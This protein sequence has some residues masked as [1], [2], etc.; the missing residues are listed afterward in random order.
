MKA[1]DRIETVLR[2]LGIERAHFAGALSQEI[3]PLIEMGRVAS[4]SLVNPNRV[5]IEETGKLGSRLGILTGSSGLPAEQVARARHGLPE[6]AVTV[7]DGCATA[8][9]TDMTREYPEQVLEMLL[10]RAEVEGC[11]PAAPAPATVTAGA[12][13]GEVAGIRYEIDRS[14]SGKPPLVLLPLLLA[15]SQWEPVLDQLASSFTVIRLGGAH[16]GMVAMLESRGRE[17]GYQRILRSVFD[18]IAARPGEVVLEVGCGTG[19]LSRWIATRTRRANPIIAMDLNPYFLKEA[20]AL[21]EDAGLSETL[22]FR[23]G[24]AEVLPFADDSVDITF[25]ST[26][27]EECD[28]DRMLAEMVRVA[29]PGG[30][31]AVVV[32]AADAHAIC[33]VETEPGIKEIVES[34]YRSVSPSGCADASLYRRFAESGLRE[35]R[36]F[37]DLLTLTDPDGAAWAYREPFFLAQMSL[38]EREAWADAKARAVAAGTFVFA[39]PVHC[40]VGRKPA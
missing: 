36:Y 22:E 10:A 35:C 37:P 32:R 33:G 13:A 12:A 19:V 4:L 24:N 30:R 2:S 7:I 31:V 34:P 3:E 27:M 18:E 11:D 6:A 17:P 40:A 16:L 28:A 38:P 20:A 5:S 1:S 15:P 39:S 25:S 23:K 8:A 21:A 29:R 9:W 26:V 14:E